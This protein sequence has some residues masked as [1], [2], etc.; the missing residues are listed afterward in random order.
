[1]SDVSN[2][3]IVALLAVALVVSVAGTMYSVSELGA[4]GGDYSVLSG[5]VQQAS[6]AGTMTGVLGEVVSLQIPNANINLGTGWVDMVSTTNQG[7]VNTCNIKTEG[8]YRSSDCAGDWASGTSLSAAANSFVLKS[9][10]SVLIDVGYTMTGI[11][12]GDLEGTNSVFGLKSRCISAAPCGTSNILVN[13][14]V[15][16]D[17][18]ANALTPVFTNLK[19][20]AGA[21][22]IFVDLEWTIDQD[23]ESGDKGSV[24]TFTASNAASLP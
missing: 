15:V 7:I 14:A 21:N 17:A 24:F 9:S 23:E 6:Q 11:A 10:S 8:T 5:A 13:T 2:R 19:N 1:M 18:G 20:Q 16:H 12:D 4:L 3:T 22:E